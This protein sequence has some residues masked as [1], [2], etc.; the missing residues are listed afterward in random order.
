MKNLIPSAIRPTS[1]VRS[2]RLALLAFSAGLALASTALA[3][4]NPD[5]GGRR[6]G[7]DTNGQDRGGR[8]NF[9]PAEM[10]ARMLSSIRERLEVTDEEE[11]KLISARLLKVSEL[12]RASG[13]GMG[14]GGRGGPPPGGGGGSDQRGSSRGTRGGGSPEMELLSSALRDKMPDAEIKMRLDRLREARKAN[15]A[16]LAKAQEELRQ[17]LS[18]RQEAVAVMFGLL[19]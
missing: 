18:V 6:R 2:P 3:Q 17:V 9:D 5:T 7:G 15:E 19:P 12:R 10:Q 11:W 8:G 1:V 14:F 13:G 16:A 4:N